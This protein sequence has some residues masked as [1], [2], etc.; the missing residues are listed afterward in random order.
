MRIRVFLLVAAVA[1]LVLLAAACGGGGEQGA[2]TTGAA[3]TFMQLDHTI[4]YGP[5]IINVKG[6]HISGSQLSLYYDVLTEPGVRA[7]PLEPVAKLVY[8]DGEEVF[9]GTAGGFIE[10]LPDGLV[11]P[12]TTDPLANAP[13]AVTFTLGRGPEEPFTVEFG[14]FITGVPGRREYVVPVSGI[15]TVEMEGDTFEVSAA[16]DE[17]GN[18]AIRA[19]RVPGAEPGGFLVYSVSDATLRDDLGDSYRFLRG[20]T[21]FRKTELMKPIADRTIMVF[22]G[23]VNPKAWQ[24]YLTVPD[25]ARVVGPIDGGQFSLP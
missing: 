3:G 9:G 8:P 13:Y 11:Q 19:Q 4:E 1:P 22:A 23:P 10:T 15:A 24:L 25:S 14:R 20:E 16:P 5:M 12:H 2:P 6:A 7:D 21:G 17:E 18:I